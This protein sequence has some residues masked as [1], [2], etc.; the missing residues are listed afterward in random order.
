MHQNF[1]LIGR[2]HEQR[3]QTQVVQVAITVFTETEPVV[4]RKGRVMVAPGI[5]Y[6]LERDLWPGAIG[7]VRSC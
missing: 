6:L 5:T 7:T 3:E 1:E 4:W 2:L